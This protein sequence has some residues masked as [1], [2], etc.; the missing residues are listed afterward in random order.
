MD[1]QKI[2]TVKEW[3]KSK[4]KH[5]IRSFYGLCAYNRRYVTGFADI[6]KPLTRL[7]EASF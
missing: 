5:D 2:E 7:M 4:N 1:P 3:P 6:G